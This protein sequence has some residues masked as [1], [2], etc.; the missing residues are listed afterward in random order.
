MKSIITIPLA[1]AVACASAE[2]AIE[3]SMKPSSSAP[4][5]E[6]TANPLIAEWTG[7]YGG[8]PPWDKVRPEL[9]PEAFQQAIDARRAEINAIANVKSAPT[10]QNTFV[11]LQNSGRMLNRVSTL[12][13][14]MTSNMNAPAYQA[15]DREWSPKLAAASDEI[16]F[17][18]PLFHRIETVYNSRTSAW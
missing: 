1:L 6:T 11:P 2:P 12:F 13:G 16:V 3:T 18:E 7:P 9:F 10:F 8:V 4:Q 5:P 15:L 17:N 14:V